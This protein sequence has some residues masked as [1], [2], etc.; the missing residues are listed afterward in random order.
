MERNIRITKLDYLR[1]SKLIEIARK[2]RIAELKSLNILEYELIRAEKVIS[3]K[4]DPDHILQTIYFII[5]F[6]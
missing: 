2:E 3:E 4:I 6:C 1:L 5:F